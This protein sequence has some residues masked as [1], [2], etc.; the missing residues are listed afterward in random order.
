MHT[1][2]NQI[3]ITHYLQFTASSQFIN[4]FC[5]VTH[6]SECALPKPQGN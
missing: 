5:L 3:T 6:E 1:T 4:N 2:E